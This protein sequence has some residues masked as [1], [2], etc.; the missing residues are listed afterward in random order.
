[1]KARS[2]AI[3]FAFSLLATAVCAEP[4]LLASEHRPPDA[5]LEAF[6]AQVGV[7]LS[8][9]AV[10]A[11]LAATPR[12]RLPEIQGCLGDFD[13]HDGGEPHEGHSHGPFD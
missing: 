12:I 4:P 11:D 3:A 5:A 1:M 8:Q 6:V 7:D 2:C 10:L 9:T 13:P